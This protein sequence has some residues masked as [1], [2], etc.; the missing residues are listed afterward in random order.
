MMLMSLFT[1]FLMTLNTT[2][3]PT[4]QLLFTLIKTECF[5]STNSP[6]LLLLAPASDKGLLITLALSVMAR[7]L[8]LMST[9]HNFRANMVAFRY[10]SSANDWGTHWGF[11]AWAE[12]GLTVDNRAF[13]A[14]T[15]MTVLATCVFAAV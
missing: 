11:A 12:L 5:P 2:R 13:L 1:R 3:V 10:N 6:N 4:W 15:H 7:F 8:T 14:E 9:V